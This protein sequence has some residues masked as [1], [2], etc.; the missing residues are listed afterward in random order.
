MNSLEFYQTC[1]QKN[2]KSKGPERALNQYRQERQL[3]NILMEGR[4]NQ[5]M[6]TSGD[7]PKESI[8]HQ[9]I[10]FLM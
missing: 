2:Q 5:I 7:Q 9:L 8:S 3:V 10:P 1:I 4:H 6:Q